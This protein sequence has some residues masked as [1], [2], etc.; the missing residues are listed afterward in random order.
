[1]DQY[2]GRL[3][4]AQ[5]Q[6]MEPPQLWQERIDSRWQADAPRIDPNGEFGDQLL[7]K[8]APGRPL[9]LQGPFAQLHPTL[10][11]EQQLAN[12][13]AQSPL[14]FRYGMGESAQHRLQLQ[15]DLE[16]DGEVLYPTLGTA[17]FSADD[18]LYQ[19]AAC[20]VYNDWLAELVKQDSV[21][22]KAMALLPAK[23]EIDAIATEA[24]RAAELGHVG[25]IL[26]ARHALLPY[27]APEWDQL[28]GELESLG[29]VCVFHLGAEE[30]AGFTPV[31]PGAA[32]I[33]LSTGKY[34][35]NE[36]LQMLVWGGAAM[37]YPDLRWGLTGSGTGWIATQVNLMD[38]WWND[39]KGWMQPRLDKAP[40]L[41]WLSQFH[42]L[43]HEDSPGVA[44]REIS[45]VGNQ[46]WGAHGQ[47]SSPANGESY[48]A[49][50]SRTLGH[51][52]AD[53]IEQMVSG[54][55]ARLFGFTG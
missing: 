3:L 13:T 51:L 54:N 48:R 52:P 15:A 47:A 22:L 17:I 6:V 11:P 44:T 23:T 46:L 2:R 34:E 31:G 5:S 40:S 25:V 24:R 10:N 49:Q 28:W 21:R 4:S 38:H 1:M 14:P 36:V 37:R 12:A 16:L 26:P 50:V 43:F 27:N 42:A 20:Q 29:L 39:H 7:I 30:G 18:G 32:G 19:L 55:T 8:G 53:E 45:G 41:Y 35:L 33:L 9:Q